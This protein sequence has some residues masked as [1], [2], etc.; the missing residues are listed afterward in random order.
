M[1]VPEPTPPPPEPERPP[2]QPP[3]PEP[4]KVPMPQWRVDYDQSE[5]MPR[6]PPPAPE[7][8]MPDADAA[9]SRWARG[10][11]AA[12]A[13]ER[14]NNASTNPTQPHHHHHRTPRE[15][16]Y[17]EQRRDI[18]ATNAAAERVHTLVPFNYDSDPDD[19]VDDAADELEHQR[20]A[21]LPQYIVESYKRPTEHARGGSNGFWY[22][23]RL[24]RNATAD[25][26]DDDHTWRD[27]RNGVYSGESVA[28]V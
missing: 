13:V 10:Y 20:E 27:V 4:Q 2:T 19:D 16:E 12:R 21:H 6:P 9:A 22:L 25:G 17:R 1:P 18:S 14:F 23:G 3:A 26:P 5:P 28:Y 8:E 24:F 15:Y 11:G 7:P